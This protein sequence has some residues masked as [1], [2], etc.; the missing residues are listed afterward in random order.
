MMNL[1]MNVRNLL[2]LLLAVGGCGGQYTLSLSDHVAAAGRDAPVVARLQ[3]NDFFVLN[4]GISDAWLSFSSDGGSPR[5]ACTDKLGYAGTA[6]PANGKPGRYPLRVDYLDDL[7]EEVFTKAELFVFDPAGP[8][9]AVALDDLPA[10]GSYEATC[11][12]MVLGRLSR[13][14]GLIYLTGK[15]ISQYGRLHDQL[16]KAKYPV[17]AILPWRRQRW[18][19]VHEGKLPKIVI[20]TRLVSQ[21]PELRKFLPGLSAGICSSPIA[22]KAYKSAGMRA[23][24][25]GAAA[26][27][28]GSDGRGSWDEL[29][30]TEIDMESGS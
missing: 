17:G 4:L 3:R 12:K 28:F 27:Q 8:V 30:A 15:P 11:A 1:M 24:V 20:S 21:L 26:K 9:V 13:R 14:A 10:D 6:L 2:L 25:V 19:I 29:R 16:G 18:H 7:G 23:I 22:A 5:A